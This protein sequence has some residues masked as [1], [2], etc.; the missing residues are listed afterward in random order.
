MQDKQAIK[1][2]LISSFLTWHNS[3][4]YRKE[5]R[6]QLILSPGRNDKSLGSFRIDAESGLWIDK[7]TGKGGDII[8]LYAL[9]YG[10]SAAEVIKKFSRED[11]DL[12][13]ERAALS[14]LAGNDK[15]PR[16]YSPV[17]S[18]DYQ[19][20][21]I[22]RIERPG[23]KKSFSV[24]HKSGSQWI[25]RRPEKPAKGWPLL[26]LNKIKANPAAVIV[27][28]EGEKAAL[29]IPS[30]FIGTT[31][32]FGATSWKDADFSPLEG[33]EVIL[34]PD[35]DSTGR[36]CMNGVENLLNG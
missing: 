23:Q 27:V 2:N 9:I 19:I 25:N 35:N 30:P 16:H 13:G 18:Y 24:W 36:D 11:I 4:Q 7:A 21:I 20:L 17:A 28:C 22:D 29:S 6:D 8:D 26:N 33:R 14:L 5:G 15:P 31:W 10:L 1:Q 32:P 34:F 3:N 12:Q